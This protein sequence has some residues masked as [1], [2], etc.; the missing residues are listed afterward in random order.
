MASKISS[1]TRGRTSKPN[2]PLVKTARS[3][4]NSNRAS[5]PM[6]LKIEH[7]TGRRP[8]QLLINA[9]TSVYGLMV[10]KTR[11]RLS[12]LPEVAK[13]FNPKNC[14]QVQRVN[15][16]HIESPSKWLRGGWV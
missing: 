1:Q 14:T 6:T 12:E 8:R 9:K 4:P 11:L 3:C 15:M 16:N 7:Y 5:V 13:H 2:W 10:A